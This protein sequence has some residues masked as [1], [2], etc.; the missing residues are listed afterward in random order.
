[1][2]LASKIRA[3]PQLGLKE[4]ISTRLLVHAAKLI[5]SGMPIRFACRVAIAEPVTDDTNVLRSLTDLIAL[6]L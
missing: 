5:K 6:Q 4:T 2:S 3:I 1:V